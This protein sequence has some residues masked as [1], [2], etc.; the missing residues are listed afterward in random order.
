MTPTELILI[1]HGET[2]TPGTLLGWTD[3]PL[4][5]EGVA[6]M[7]KVSA[8]LAVEKFDAIYSSDLDRS[9]ASAKIMAKPHGMEVARIPALREM[10]MGRWDGVLFS[11]LMETEPEMLRAFWA[12]KENCRTP[13]GESLSDLRSRVLPAVEELRKKHEGGRIMVVAHGGVNRVI[14]FTALGLSLSRYYK[15]EQRCGSVNRI[16]YFPDGNEVVTLVNG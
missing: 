16:S 14:L 2:S 3:S 8:K 11:I 7:E 13:G 9:V 4:S 10:N 12:D 1:R 5:V 15:V 6:T